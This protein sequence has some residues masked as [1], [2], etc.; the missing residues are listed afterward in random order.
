MKVLVGVK[1]GVDANVKVR[2]RANAS[3]VETT[4]LKRS[5]NPFL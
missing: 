2:V 1:L 4:G 5:F 3:G